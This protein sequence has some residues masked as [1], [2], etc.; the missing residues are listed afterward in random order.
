ML[1]PNRLTEPREVAPH[2]YSVPPIFAP[3]ASSPLLT[4][5]AVRLSKIAPLQ[6]RSPE[7]LAPDKIKRPFSK[8]ASVHRRS[9]SIFALFSPTCPDSFALLRDTSP[10]I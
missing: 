1:A 5:F 10:P 6:S 4:P 7:I 2:R 9:P 8:V 3:F